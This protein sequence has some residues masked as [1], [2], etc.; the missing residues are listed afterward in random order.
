MGRF[1]TEVD[2]YIFSGLK[3]FPSRSELELLDPWSGLYRA[4]QIPLEEFFR[5]AA[6][7]VILKRSN[8]T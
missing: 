1:I 7:P 4:P 3:V 6:G 2:V 8:N 5:S